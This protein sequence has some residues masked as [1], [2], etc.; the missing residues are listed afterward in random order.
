MRDDERDQVSPGED[1]GI[2]DDPY[3]E[4]AVSSDDIDQVM[5]A[6]AIAGDDPVGQLRNLVSWLIDH[7]VDEPGAAIIETAE[8]GSSVQIQL[9][10]PESDLGKVIGRGGRIAKSIRTA[11]MI[12]ASRHNLRVSLDIEGQQ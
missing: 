4:E 1:V 5:N 7:L 6:A 2:S 9:R 3:D 8:Q 12:A 10:L 11:L